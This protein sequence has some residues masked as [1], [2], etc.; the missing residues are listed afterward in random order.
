MVLGGFGLEMSESELRE[1]CDCTAFGTEALKAVNAARQLGFTKTAK[2][3]LSFIELGA[4]VTDAQ[5]PIVF[6]DLNPIDGLDDIH[7]LV[8]IGLGKDAISVYDPMQG[9]RVLPFQTFITAW[10]MRHNLAILVER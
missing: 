2:Y 9:E 3:T 6:V 10:A 5:A 1:L 4:L 8:V 7:T